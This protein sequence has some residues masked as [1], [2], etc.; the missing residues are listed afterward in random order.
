MLDKKNQLLLYT[1]SVL[2]QV[3][4]PVNTLRFFLQTLSA[5]T[6]QVN[7]LIPL[8]VHNYALWSLTKGRDILFTLEECFLFV[9]H[10]YKYFF[11]FTF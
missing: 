5:E 6:K 9:L 8:R 3:I 11:E 4:L 10:F 1:F 7:F 2:T